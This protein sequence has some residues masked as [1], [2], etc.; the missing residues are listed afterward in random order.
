MEHFVDVKIKV[1]VPYEF[2]LFDFGVIIN[3]LFNEH[4][5]H[6][7]LERSLSLF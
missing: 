4:I 6:F 7:S 2:C 5:N 1:I 3:R